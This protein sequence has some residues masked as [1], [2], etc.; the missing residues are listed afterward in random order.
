[1]NIFKA[2]IFFQGSNLFQDSVACITL[3]CNV[4]KHCLLNKKGEKDKMKS[5]VLRTHLQFDKK[6]KKKEN[7]H[8]Q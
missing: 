7:I 8:Q 1:M 2:Q 5:T 6:K 3:S 4:H